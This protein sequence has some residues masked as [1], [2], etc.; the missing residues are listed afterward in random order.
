MPHEHSKENIA[1]TES[2]NQNHQ[3]KKHQSK[4]KKVAAIFLA[5]LAVTAVVLLAIDPWEVL[6]EEEAVP[7]E[8]IEEAKELVGIQQPAIQDMEKTASIIGAVEPVDQ[9]VVIPEVS[10]KVE[11]VHV[12]EGDEVSQGDLLFTMEDDD[13]RLQL[14]EAQAAQRAAENQL[15]EAEAGAREGEKAEAESSVETARKSKEQAERELERV[16]ALHEEGF[17]SDQELEQAQLQYDNA[18]EQLNTAKAY[19]D[20]VEEGPREEQIESLKIQIEQAET[21]VELAERNL[22]RTRVTSPA[23]GQVA[24]LEVKE[25]ELAGTAEPAAIIKAPA[26]QVT[27]SLPDQYIN[28]VFEGDQV[29]V[30]VPAAQQEN[31]KGSITHISDLPPEGER[32]Y[33]LEILINGEEAVAGKEYDENANAE[34]TGTNLRSGMYARAL[35]TVE[36]SEEALTLPR[37][38]LIRDGE[39]YLVYVVNEDNILESREV[40]TGIGR[41]GYLE[42]VSGLEKDDWVVIEG[43]ENVSEGEEVETT[44]DPRTGD[45]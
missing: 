23:E 11:N 13:H 10:G 36:R 27:A 6:S 9:R 18:R 21:A 28:Q 38:A 44:E 5:V 19:L 39:K 24:L 8:E 7:Q 16:K 25:G 32:A 45:Q 42:I 20:M 40:E 3:E 29:E 35:I 30:E 17:V 4:R 41:E 22:S 14:K 15:A 26:M 12:E 33:P 1:V 31:I 34:E 37:H 2:D 43:M